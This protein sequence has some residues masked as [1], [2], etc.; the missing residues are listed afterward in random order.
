MKPTLIITAWTADLGEPWASP[1]EFALAVVERVVQAW[2]AGADVV[3]LPEF[4]WLGL[5]RFA[6]GL[7]GVARLFWDTLWPEISSALSQS[8]KCVVLGTVPCGGATGLLNRAIILS[9]GMGY[10]QDKLYLTPW[11]KEF[12]PG[13]GIR[14]WEFRGWRLATLVCLDVEL[15]EHSI[16]LREQRVDLLLV[17]SATETIL[18]VERIARCASARAV[19]CGLYVVVSQLVGTS[20]SSLVDENVGRL[21][22]YTPSQAAFRNMERMDE[23]EVYTSGWHSRTWALSAQGL[24]RMRRTRIETN[25]ALLA[26]RR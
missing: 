2:Q 7:A 9:D 19:E 18:G 3:V 1:Q 21:S 10:F 5:E 13:E 8:G 20:V 14:P 4:L 16:A 23:S 24:N 15:P 22:L 17:P 26:R 25:P 12:Q 11:E 6:D